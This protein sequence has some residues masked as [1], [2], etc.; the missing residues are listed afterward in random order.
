MELRKEKESCYREKER[1]ESGRKGKAEGKERKGRKDKERW[2]EQERQEV[3]KDK[4][5]KTGSFLYYHHNNAIV[6]LERR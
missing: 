2:R 3:S 5:P 6:T 4:A 1:A